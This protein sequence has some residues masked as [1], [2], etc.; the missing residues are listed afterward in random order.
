[1]PRVLQAGE[2]TLHDVKTKFGLQHVS[3]DD[4]F[5]E[6]Q[7][8]GIEITETEKEWLD[9]VRSD[10]LSLEEYP[11]HEEIVK[12]AVLAPLLS[13]AGF[14]RYPFYPDAEVNI[15]DKDGEETVRGKIDVLI[16]KQDFWVTVIEA[17]NKQFSLLK[18]LPQALFYMMGSPHPE[19]STFGLM[20]NGSHFTF[21]KLIQQETP[22]YGL[23]EEFS[24]Y[25][26]ENELYAVL[27]ILRMLG[28]E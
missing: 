14:F 15:E 11:F 20:T 7:E 6:W 22:Q 8:T 18:A 10:F 2:L 24:L 12:L 5:Q 28:E 27:R 19:K 4:F 23:S 17:K 9:R 3:H 26:R 25:R 13:L 1:M 21:I 16:V